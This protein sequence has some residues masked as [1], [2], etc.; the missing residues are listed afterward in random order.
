MV[1]QF[2]IRNSWPIISNITFIYQ[3]LLMVNFKIIIQIRK[4]I[5]FNIIE[6]ER[7]SS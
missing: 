2:S 4:Q 5:K 3:W 6:K 7:E 1:I